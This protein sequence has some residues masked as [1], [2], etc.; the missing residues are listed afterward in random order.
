MKGISGYLCRLELTLWWF[1]LVLWGWDFTNNVDRGQLEDAAL[2][3]LILAARLD[4]DGL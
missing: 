4:D 1:L 3:L 2:T